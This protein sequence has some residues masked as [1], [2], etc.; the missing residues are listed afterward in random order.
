MHSCVPTRLIDG[1]HDAVPDAKQ[2]VL[3]PVASET[4]DE[5]TNGQRCRFSQPVFHRPR[6][7]TLADSFAGVD[8]AGI[9]KRLAKDDDQICALEFGEK[10]KTVS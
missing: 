5:P 3:L 8:A 1:L 7:I 6:T 9:C 10:L 2:H 4:Q